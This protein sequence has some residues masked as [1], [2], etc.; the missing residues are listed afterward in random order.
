[1]ASSP[2]G[3][4][5]LTEAATSALSTQYSKPLP[6]EA[7]SCALPLDQPRACHVS[8]PISAN[9]S[10]VM[11]KTIS[12]RRHA[13]RATANSS[14]DDWMFICTATNTKFEGHT[15]C[16]S[17]RPPECLQPASWQRQADTHLHG[18]KDVARACSSAHL[19]LLTHT[20][21]SH[22]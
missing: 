10:P 7:A 5:C 18:S 14:P 17:S 22:R 1:M 16:R 6:A 2:M 20:T 4:Y 21:L 15:S 13:P 19:Y 8:P 11:D 9:F 3:S 12:S